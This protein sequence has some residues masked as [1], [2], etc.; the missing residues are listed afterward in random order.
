MT[1]LTD[2]IKLK[3]PPA[4]SQK[5]I[6]FENVYT[7]KKNKRTGFAETKRYH[8]LSKKCQ[9]KRRMHEIFATFFKPIRSQ[10]HIFLTQKKHRKS[11]EL[12]KGYLKGYRMQRCTQIRQTTLQFVGNKTKRRI[13]KWV[14]QENKAR[15][16]FRKRRFLTP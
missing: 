11:L 6:Q 15:Q 5:P 14:L 8:S 12:Q 16:I 10:C 3:Q 9:F 7:R 4:A 13:S 1:F 2:F